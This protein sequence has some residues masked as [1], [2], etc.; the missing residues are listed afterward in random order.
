MEKRGKNNKENQ[1]KKKGKF[2]GGRRQGKMRSSWLPTGTF[3]LYAATIT[4][5]VKHTTQWPPPIK[6]VK[7]SH[8]KGEWI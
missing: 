6:K 1:E 7:G 5:W 2:L 4:A 3:D 8:Q